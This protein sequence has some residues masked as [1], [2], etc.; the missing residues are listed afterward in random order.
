MF[1][2]NIAKSAEAM[3][4]RWAIKKV[5]KFLLKKK[6]GQLILGDIDLNQLDVQL[7]AG[8]IQLSDLALNVDYIN[9]KFG[10][11]T[12][13]IV[14]EGSIGSLLVSMPWKG[15][16]CQIEVDELELVLAPHGG[17]ISVGSETSNF[18]QNGNSGITQD[19]CATEPEMIDSTATASSVDVHEGVKT[20]AKMVKWLLTSFHLKIRKLIVAFDPS[21]GGGKNKGFCRTLVLRIAEVEC[22]TDISEDLN[23][24]YHAT[25][26]NFL[27]LS[28][29]TNFVKFQGAILEFLQLDGDDNHSNATTPIV[30]GERGGFSGTL[31]LSIPWNNGS[32]DIRKVDADVYIDPLQL[33]FQ[34]SS[35]K[36]FLYLWDIFKD[37]GKNG[38]D[39]PPDKAT[40]SVYFNAA[41]HSQSQESF[42]ADFC[43][44]RG[45]ETVT[46]AMLPGSHFISDWVPSSISRN[47]RDKVE[48]P[49][50]GASVDQFFECFDGLRNSQS[51]LGSSGILNWTCSVFSAI[52]AA[53]NLASGSLHIPSEQKHVETNLK[54]TFAGISFRLSFLDEDQFHSR[55]HKPSANSYV[56]YIGAKFKDTL[57][58]LQ[59]C[60]REMNFEATVGNIELADH[61]SARADVMG[62]GLP[63]SS[64]DV[65]TQVA[66]IAKVQAAVEATLPPFLLSTSTRDTY[67]EE[68][69]NDVVKV[70][71]LRTAG[72]SKCHLSVA[73][74]PSNGSFTGPISFSLKLPPLVFW[75]NFHVISMLVDLFKEI[76]ES[77]EATS[78]INAFTSEAS[79]RDMGN[80]SGPHITTLSREESLTGNIFLLNARIIF[81][82]PLEKGGNSRSYSSWEQFIAL[83]FSSSEEKVQPNYSTPITS[84]K[85]RYSSTP[86]RSLQWSAGNISLYLITSTSK[87]NVESKSSGMGNLS[88]F[89]RKILSVTDGKGHLLVFSMIWQEG[90]VTGPWIVKRAKLLATSEELSSKN[91]FMG[92]GYE[93]AS[94]STVKD[95]EHFNSQTRQEMI[96]SSA[97][98]LHIHLS[99]VVISLASIEYRQL[100]SLL[101]QVVDWCTCI[102]SDE[103]S[104]VSQTS[105][106]VEFD[107]L[108]IHASTEAEHNIKKSLQSELAG[109]WHGFKLKIRKF[110]LFSVSNIGGVTD[111][112]FVWVGHGE[113][114]MWGLIT[115]VPNKEFLLIS[116]SNTVAGRG[117]G[118]GSNV[119]SSR[120]S[121]SEI[122][123]FWD[124]ENLFAHTS[125]TIIRGT[126]VAVGG[127]LDWFD[128]ISSFFTLP[129]AQTEQASEINV[130]C[131][132]S[133]ILNL[134]DIGLS[135]EPYL[136]TSL[137]GEQYIACLLA[138]SAV[139]LSNIT[140]TDSINTEY[141]I[142]FQDLG[143]LLCET[144]GLKNVGGIYSVDHLRKIGYV[145]VA[146]EAHVEALLRT[147]CKDDHLW[148]VEC[149]N[150]HIVLG[151]C[152]DT[153]SGLIRLAAQ[154]QQLFAPDLEDTV[155][156]LQTRWNNVQQTLESDGTRISNSG[157][158][159]S[160][161]QSVD[162]KSK[163]GVV[164]LMDE[165]CEDAFRLEGNWDAQSDVC[166]SKLHTLF[167]DS[168]LGEVCNLHAK[169][170]APEFIEGYFLSDLLPLSELS[171][172][173][174]SPK[175]IKSTSTNIKDKEVGRGKS[176][177]YSDASLMILENHVSEVSEQ[178][179]PQR[180]VNGEVPCN[181]SESD[182]CG[183]LGGRVLFK[184]VNVIW[185]LYAGS[186]WHNFHRDITACLELALSGMDVQYNLFPDGEVF[187]SKLSLSIKDFCLN[188]NSKDAP[189]RLVLGYYQSKD[190][191]REYTS[192]ALKL[193][194]EAV[195]PHPSIPLEEYRL[196]VALLPMRLHL[197]QCQLD[198]LISFFGGKSSLHD[199]SPISPQDSSESQM[200]PK[201][202]T[203]LGGHNITEE[204]LLPYFQAKV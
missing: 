87:E 162:L 60:P 92:K 34:P 179:G 185:R 71:L 175:D 120:V 156:H 54:A 180:L 3:F 38:E 10:A 158:A 198:F 164:N 78:T 86:S 139:K 196:R 33:R 83:D 201:K 77:F 99:S 20:I 49:D 91:K 73:S 97:F 63:C 16:G 61:F 140:V 197:H 105:V 55:D 117:D 169:G 42:F 153:T 172:N 106:H 35:I 93:F 192:K 116:C 36:C 104:R 167:G 123:H 128:T 13:V 131:G 144:S 114:N 148:E 159:Q 82:F 147:N 32:L 177:W 124:P 59:V 22:G 65:E 157:S 18:G 21:L 191:P 109:S 56:H 72:A 23:S 102:E 40:E 173:N 43:S 1:P 146:Q 113:G 181:N 69:R 168:L 194:L 24:N 176:G 74:E 31:K 11:T 163:P 130:P 88:F 202:S 190:H 95:G 101:N 127:R 182:E 4:S 39:H 5:C 90:P 108:E 75:V 203:V 151:T 125:I 30:T 200:L 89:A 2:W 46:D 14:K 138:A 67:V 8:T 165:I 84:S 145:K 142:R 29:L 19:Q 62:V 121:G 94:V 58:V 64:T 188:D 76:G 152:A 161:S 155:V 12:T 103:E 184:N 183:K 135:Y 66:L 51:A 171:L 118:E 48:E 25:V 85:K 7:S 28:R 98:F 154:L 80:C 204:A 81:C 57:L 15:K 170:S 96:L 107:F 17:D 47:R 50:F 126:V 37:V 115:G 110:E 189:W 119:L 187:V 160:T 45:K 100:H 178:V 174:Q 193:D 44:L 6:L 79:E 149:S 27:G 68:Q 122:V 136:N 53:S 111:A 143:L 186:D 137:V 150:S 199:Q 129:S 70:I 26:D 132:S 195:R 166:E 133:F 141:K 52:T 134:V 112:S 9:K 41:S